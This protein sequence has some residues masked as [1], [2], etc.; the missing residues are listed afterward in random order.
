MLFFTS[1]RSSSF[2]SSNCFFS[3]FLYSLASNKGFKQDILIISLVT[4]LSSEKLTTLFYKEIKLSRA[5]KVASLSQSFFPFSKVDICSAWALDNSSCILAKY[6]SGCCFYAHNL[7]F[8]IDL[9]PGILNVSR[10]SQGKDL[11]IYGNGPLW[12]EH[13]SG[14]S[15]GSLI[16]LI[17]GKKD[18]G[19][20]LVKIL[21]HLFRM[22]PEVIPN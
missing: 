7:T 2:Q 17:F 4:I 11:F 16:F 15:Y 10:G 19:L 6:K 14:S 1:L 13:G 18:K 3:Y 8:S 12:S 5:F 20:I 9:R 21:I 22:T